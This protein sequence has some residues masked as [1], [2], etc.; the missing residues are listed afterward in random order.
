MKNEFTPWPRAA[1]AHP[2]DVDQ[3]DERDPAYMHLPAKSRSM[4]LICDMG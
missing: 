3:A 4:I 2:H 1:L